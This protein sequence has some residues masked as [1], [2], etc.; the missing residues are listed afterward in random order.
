[1]YVIVQYVP[2][3]NLSHLEWYGSFAAIQVKV[4]FLV[5]PLS[6]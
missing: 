6:K 2:V 3:A 1:M 5:K 4:I